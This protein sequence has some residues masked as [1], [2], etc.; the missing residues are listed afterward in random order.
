[1]GSF[2][3]LGL[4]GPVCRRAGVFLIKETILGVYLAGSSIWQHRLAGLSPLLS[5][6]KPLNGFPLRMLATQTET[7]NLRPS[8]DLMLFRLRF[9]YN[10]G[11]CLFYWQDSALYAGLLRQDP[12]IRALPR[13]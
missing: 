8:Y 12:A 1:M 5:E 3:A 11:V 2:Y 4:F 13:K 9:A 10:V 6:H 7:S